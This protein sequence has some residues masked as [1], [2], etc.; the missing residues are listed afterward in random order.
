MECVRARL[1]ISSLLL[2][3]GKYATKRLSEKQSVFLL[4]CQTLQGKHYRLNCLIPIC[5]IRRSDNCKNRDAKRRLRA[6]YACC[7]P[8]AVGKAKLRTSAGTSSPAGSHAPTPTIPLPPAEPFPPLRPPDSL[9]RRVFTALCWGFQPYCSTLEIFL[10][11]DCLVQNLSED[12]GGTSCPSKTK[13]A[14]RHDMLHALGI[15][16]C[17]SCLAS[18]L[19]E[20]R[21]QQ[22]L[23]LDKPNP[24]GCPILQISPEI[25]KIGLIFYF[26]HQCLSE[27]MSQH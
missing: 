5:I 19:I 12:P 27:S 8:F 9:T 3:L 15:E 7:Q 1:S 4:P 16:I 17:P 11:R 21:A 25:F 24:L 2:F 14:N 22:N 13:K 18:Q 6:T 20:G 23:S 26:T 10:P